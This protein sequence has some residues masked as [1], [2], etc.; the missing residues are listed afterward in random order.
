MPLP[1]PLPP[2]VPLASE[3]PVG[4]RIQ[5]LAA[6]FVARQVWVWAFCGLGVTRLAIDALKQDWL[7]FILDMGLVAGLG[8]LWRSLNRFKRAH[9]GGQPLDLVSAL[10]YFMRY[11]KVT[12]VVGVASFAGLFLAIGIGLWWWHT[13]G[14]AD[15]LTWLKA[16]AQS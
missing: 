11:V 7:N 6:P 15:V 14:A 8:S 9:Q 13:H 10:D 5:A 1:S 16:H 4:P 2:P 12:V 3:R